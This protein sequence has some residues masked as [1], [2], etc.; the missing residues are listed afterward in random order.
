MDLNE[1]EQI[2]IGTATKEFDGGPNNA[3]DAWKFF[4]AE[5]QKHDNEVAIV[6]RR[7]DDACFGAIL[8][9]YSAPDTF[10]K[11]KQFL[12]AIG[13]YYSGEDD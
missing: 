3:K 10:S 2:A 7:N 4:E 6:V 9:N 11:F 12:D 1:I 5:I 8:T 13:F